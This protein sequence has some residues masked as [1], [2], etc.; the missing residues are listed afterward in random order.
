MRVWCV[1]VVATI[2]VL[3]LDA[4]GQ[5]LVPSEPVVVAP[6]DGVLSPAA[7]GVYPYAEPAGATCVAPIEGRAILSAAYLDERPN[8]W[9]VRLDM[10]D[11]NER[12]DRASFVDESG[13]LTT[14]GY[15]RRVGR[16]R[17]RFELFA[18]TMDYD[19]HAQD[20]YY[21]IPYEQADGTRYFGGRGEFEYL[22]EPLSW[23]YNRIVL[24]IGTRAWQRR[25]YD[26]ALPTGERIE[27][28]DETWLTV[29]PYVGIETKEEMIV[30]PRMR[31]F[32]GARI[33]FTAFTSEDVSLGVTL[34]PRCGPVVQ[35]E[36]GMR[37]ER[38][39][40]SLFGETMCWG[41]SPEVDG[42]L[43]PCSTMT[44]FGC[45]LLYRF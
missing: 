15:Q 34:R 18:G 44:T 30:G 26:G 25:L 10:F 43:Q 32:G 42:Y 6:A 9:Y 8:A 35:F 11:W 20:G 29:Y 23:S 4:R 28:Y 24:G 13:L 14:I 38:L 21:L 36:L 19:G 2:G 33:G 1:L 27:G 41:E 45:R 7:D 39:A 37:N 16:G 31:L 5:E 17:F 3:S 40:V 22:V 12:L